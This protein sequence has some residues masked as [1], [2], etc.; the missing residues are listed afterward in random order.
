MPKL[1][2][3]GVDKPALAWYNAR[4]QKRE[5]NGMSHK[6]QTLKLAIGYRTVRCVECGLQVTLR[7]DY[8]EALKGVPAV[9]EG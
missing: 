9:C 4:N 8:A 7:G 1:I 6:Y 2:R 3:K 5:V